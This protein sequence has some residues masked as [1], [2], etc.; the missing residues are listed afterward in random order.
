[1]PY[2]VKLTVRVYAADHAD[3]LKKLQ[4]AVD[5]TKPLSGFAPITIESVDKITE[6]KKR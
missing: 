2:E 3:A 6:E 4:N 5:A 1:M